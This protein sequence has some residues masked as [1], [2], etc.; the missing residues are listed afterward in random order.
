MKKKNI[1][2]KNSQNFSINSEKENYYDYLDRKYKI[3]FWTAAGIII[4]E[5]LLLYITTSVICW[6]FGTYIPHP[7]SFFVYMIFLYIN[8]RHF[9]KKL[10]L[11]IEREEY[12][13][14]RRK[15]DNLKR[16]AV[17]K[18][19]SEEMTDR[20]REIEDIKRMLE[21]AQKNSRD[22]L[23]EH[24]E[25]EIKHETEKETPKRRKIECDARLDN[26]DKSNNNDACVPK[27][28]D[29]KKCLTTDTEKAITEGAEHLINGDDISEDDTGRLEMEEELA[30]LKK[31]G[32][33]NTYKLFFIN[34]K[35]KEEKE[36]NEK[37]EIKEKEEIE[38]KEEK[39][40]DKEKQ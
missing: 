19:R 17:N 27:N 4:P 13:R 28:A 22:T 37:K 16:R 25:L 8:Q 33:E 15:S 21:A 3:G 39:K 14:M 2:F 30:F 11:E 24:N 35:A 18:A 5:A 23:K 1:T 40:D 9:K 31:I 6:W 26:A 29:I 7:S 32:D 20:D 12:V 38:E 36:I 34:D 10:F